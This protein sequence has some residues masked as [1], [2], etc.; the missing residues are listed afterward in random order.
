MKLALIQIYTDGDFKI[1]D[2]LH[3]AC[4]TYLLIVKD[5]MEELVKLY[6][7]TTYSYLERLIEQYMDSPSDYTENSNH[8]IKITY[9]DSTVKEVEDACKLLKGIMWKQE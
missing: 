2:V 8:S 9:V 4:C 3:I 6:Y 1:E 7:E 5:V